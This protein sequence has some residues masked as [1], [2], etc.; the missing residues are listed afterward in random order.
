L[1]PTPGFHAVAI[2]APSTSYNGAKTEEQMTEREWANGLTPDAFKVERQIGTNGVRVSFL[3]AQHGLTRVI[4][5]QVQLLS[6]IA[7]LQ[8]KIELSPM[9][10]ISLDRLRSGKSIV[11]RAFTAK[12]HADG[13]LEMVLIA[14]FEERVVTLPLTLTPEM[15]RDL[16]E[17]I[18]S[19]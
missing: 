6:L 9:T 8:K 18:D 14:E 13:S 1:G 5:D 19:A 3:S 7:S 2:V 17:E 4:L 16:R 11:L 12:K 10:P 15:V